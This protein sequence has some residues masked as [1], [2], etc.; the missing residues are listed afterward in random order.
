MRKH[1][2]FVE[3]L[4]SGEFILVGAAFHHLVRVLRVR[5]ETPVLLID[6]AE[7]TCAHAHVS[8]IRESEATLLV[9]VLEDAI[10]AEPLWLLQ[11]L[12]KGDKCDGIVRDA[13][14]LGATRI[15]FVETEHAVVRLDGDRATLR[16]LRWQKIAEE[17]ARQSGR[18]DVP[19]VDGPEPWLDALEAVP[20]SLAR[21]VLWERADEPLIVALAPALERG[22]GIAFA[23]GPEG[24][25][26]EEEVAFARNVGWQIC[27]LGRSI[28]RTETV[29]PAV[30]GAVRI[31]IGT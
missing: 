14:E 9:G 28:L 4:H 8:E 19:Q 2:V 17:A 26:S 10:G 25:L 23:V 1:R 11:G 16:A 7:G 13:T 15:C 24:G 21:M 22:E 18:E 6:R 31:L 20:P 27:S 3:K 30:L 29:A 5:A 12:A